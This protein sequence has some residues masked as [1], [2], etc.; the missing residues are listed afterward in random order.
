LTS[1]AAIRVVVLDDDRVLAQ[2]VLV[3]LLAANG[4]R[5]AA[6][7]CVAELAAL[8][9]EAIPDLLLLDLGLPE[10]D[11]LVLTERV[12]QRHP[13]MGVVV[14]TGYQDASER[15]R[16]LI[17]GADAYLC[18]PVSVRLLLATL[19]SV[20]R[21]LQARPGA[22]T[23]LAAD[24]TRWQLGHGAWQLRAPCG[25]AV[26]LTAS[27]R[28]IMRCLFGSIGNVIARDRLIAM[29]TSDIHTFDPHRLDALLHRLRRKV[30]AKCGQA[31]P[32]TAVP[33]Q[34][35]VFLP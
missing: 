33:G 28:P 16:G 35:Y 21:R 19:Q 7:A 10:G 12:R 2:H 6:L 14:L 31:L 4:Y 3:P 17:G 34:G 15:I 30:V 5:A 1:H 26:A 27:E 25:T 13:Q 9:A 18:K 22:S 8:P 20:A 32:L 29:L 23:T 11:G 24:S